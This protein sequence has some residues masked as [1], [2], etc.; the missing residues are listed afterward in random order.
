MLSVPTHIFCFS[1]LRWNF[2]YQRPQH[3]LSRAARNLGVFYVEEPIFSQEESGVRI[4]RDEA[5]GVVVVTPILPEGLS[6]DEINAAQRRVVNELL[7]DVEPSRWVAWYYT[8]MALQFTQ[9]LSPNLR[10]YDNMDELS[11][12]AGAP[13]GILDLERELMS[14][15][16]LM[17]VGGQSLYESKRQRHD[18]IH[19]FPSSVDTAH[20]KSA[21]ER[22]VDPDDQREIPHPRIG[23]FGVID[24]RMNMD[25]VAG[26]A[27][28]RP[29][30]QLVMIGPTAKISAESLPRAGNIHWLGC[31]QYQE[32][33]IYLSGWDVGIMPFAL[34]DATRFISPTKTPEFLAAG[35]PVVSTAITD[36]VNPY[37]AAGH[38]E[39]A[40]NAEEFVAKIDLL[41]TRPKAHWLRAVDAHLAEMSWD[42]TWARMMLHIASVSA[43]SKAA[44]EGQLV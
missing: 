33:P 4:H 7:A 20:F 37:G 27:A 35:V 28:L 13:Q 36:V 1:H 38:V 12:F 42:K 44:R 17:F 39:I 34:N 31:K 3:L 5:C 23:F 14:K 26:I 41:L 43:E 15:C 30:W 19:V 22:G 2:V 8:P 11:A 24:E 9:H 16:D 21:R 32:L 40:S 10:L 25:I 6:K 18:N 29:Q